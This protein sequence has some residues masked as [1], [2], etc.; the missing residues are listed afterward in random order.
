[1]LITVSLREPFAAALALVALLAGMLAA[2]TVP[3]AA[4]TAAPSSPAAPEIVALPSAHSPLVAIRLL[5]KAG[6]IDDP[7]GKEGL[8]ALTSQ[9]VAQAGTAKRSYSQLL[10]DLYPLAAQINGSADREVTVFSGTVPRAA[11]A[12]FVKL[13]EEALLTPAFSDSDFHRNQQQLLSFIT[14]T[15]RSSNDELLGLEALQDK[16]FAGHPYGHPSVGTVAGLKSITLNDVRE[17]YRT[18][19]TRANLMIGVA[20]GYPA[21]FVAKLNGDLSRLPAGTRADRK[22]PPPAP[23]SGRNITVIDKETASVGV[24]F[25]F[26][27][28]LTRK[29]ADYYPLMVANSYL[30]EHRTFNGVLME[31][32]RQLRGLNYGDY[33]YIEY[34]DTP[35]FT[36]HPTPN[37]PRHDQYFSV[38]VRPVVPA[39][40]QFALRAALYEVD[41]LQSQGMTQ[42]EFELTRNFV[43]NYSKLWVQDLSSRL[44][45]HMD[46]RYYGMPY[47]IDEIE[48]RLKGLTV[49]DVNRAAKKYLTTDNFDAI[50][51][52]AHAKELADTLQRD[53]PSPKKYNSQVSND[54]LEA[55]KTI[56]TLKVH[57]TK[58]EV[59]PVAQAFEN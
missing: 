43:V 35:P 53:E 32:L 4:Q 13:F 9:M 44:G 40:A 54:V 33:S 11:L 3:A 55:D 12:P 2:V 34:W 28:A 38:W 50:V 42:K 19:Y 56:T 37:V 1:M 46:S 7:A 25:G 52:S 24:H 21:G 26:P 20:G 29:D 49:D 48:Q 16:I 51:V 36:S 30:G 59:L 41:R 14:D 18:H 6:S 17:F 27:L 10:E 22:V 57:P 31:Q 8:A 58:V 45:Y 39:D 47:F 5:F 23:V 15:L